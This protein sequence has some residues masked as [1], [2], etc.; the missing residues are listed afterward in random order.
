MQG[1]IMTH[2]LCHNFVT[3]KFSMRQRLSSEE[4]YRVSEPYG[5]PPPPPCSHTI[6][7]S[8]TPY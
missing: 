5:P 1:Y 6:H 4:V 8:L 7:T 2:L 3:R